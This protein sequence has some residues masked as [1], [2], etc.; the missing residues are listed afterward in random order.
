MAAMHGNAIEGWMTVAMSVNFGPISVRTATGTVELPLTQRYFVKGLMLPDGSNAGT[1]PW[2]PIPATLDQ[3]FA[4]AFAYNVTTLKNKEPTPAA[5]A[6]FEAPTFMPDPGTTQPGAQHLICVVLSLVCMKE[7]ADFE[8]TGT[9]G[10]GRFY[11]HLMIMSNQSIAGKEALQ[12]KISIMRPFKAGY[13]GVARPSK[14][15]GHPDMDPEIRPLLVTES[16]V[17]RTTDPLN[18]AALPYWDLLFDYI[19]PTIPFENPCT[20]VDYST[21]RRKLSRLLEHL[22]YSKVA[23]DVS[24]RILQWSRFLP[25]EL[26]KLAPAVGEILLTRPSLRTVMYKEGLSSYLLPDNLK[27][28]WFMP[29]VQR[30]IIKLPRQGA[31]DSLHL[32]PR[33]KAHRLIGNKELAEDRWQLTIDSI[34]MAPVCEHDCVHTHWRWGLEFENQKSVFNKYPLMGF[35]E[36]TVSQFAGTGKPYQLLGSPMVPLNQEVKLELRANNHFVYA[37][38]CKDVQPGVW[39]PVFHHGSAYPVGIMDLA[40]PLFEATKSF[41][42]TSGESSEFYWNLRYQATTEGPLE[43]IQM[44]GSNLWKAMLARSTVRLHLKVFEEPPEIRIEAMLANAKR[45]FAQYEVD[46]VE[47]SRETYDEEDDVF[48]RFNTLA[49]GEDAPSDAQVD[50]FDLR[51][52]AESD[53]VVIY[54]VRT[55]VPAQA[56]CALHPPDRPGAVVSATLATEWTLAHQV[57]HV[58]G[59][60]HVADVAEERLMTARSTLSLEELPT[61]DRDEVSAV[62]ASPFCK[63]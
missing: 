26:A 60:G 23:F 13:Y 4:A 8:P 55:L 63:V 46:V 36:D 10:M 51:D 38:S 58:L 14:S 17:T 50:L 25:S 11:P 24:M 20:V 47:V 42:S 35:K 39:Q 57:A 12:T 48:A 7:R 3:S 62:V 61:L 2:W 28:S 44:T 29:F 53:D 54:F 32:S 18:I 19:S 52:G 22:D 21:G 31:F 5:A 33:M 34:G 1:N 41:I 37:A 9:V 6:D 27:K 49:I 30:D 45:V 43:R 56:G 59:L 40:L 15:L 16:N